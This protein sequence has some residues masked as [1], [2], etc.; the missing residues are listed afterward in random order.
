MTILVRPRAWWYNKIPL[1]VL[2]FLLL[3]DGTRLTLTAGVAMMG[4]LVLICSVA[5]YGYAINELFDQD[6][7]HR[8]GRNNATDTLGNRGMLTIIVASAVTAL[9]LASTLAGT[10]GGAL[11]AGVLVLP[12]AYSMP[13]LRLKE[14]G[15]WGACADAAAAHVYPAMLALAAVQHEWLRQSSL[16]LILA[17][18]VWSAAVGLR[19]ILSH[20][21]HSADRDLG[22]GLRTIVHRHGH[23]KVRLGVV[24]AILPI[25]LV[26]FAGVV[27][28]AGAGTPFAILAVIFLLCEFLKVRS[29]IFPVTVFTPKGEAYIP[30]VDEGAYKVW[31]PLALL[32]DSAFVDPLYLALVP[33]YILLFRP[34]VVHEWRQLRIGGRMI[35]VRGR[36]LVGLLRAGHKTKHV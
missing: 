15:W 19:G 28:E 11:T 22:A 7:D 2:T 14:R 12:L 26:S 18:V 35:Y 30:F 17:M 13:P 29:G 27:V 3:L 24:L 23:A 20:Q 6:E 33:L 25:E 8:A 36:T 16:P 32:I 31:G 34:R 21:L 10:I 9:A 4:L 1:S 5:N